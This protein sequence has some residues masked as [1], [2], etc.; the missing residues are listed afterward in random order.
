MTVVDDEPAVIVKDLYKT[1]KLP[2]D[3]HSGIKQYLLTLFKGKK[4][5]KGYEIQHVLNDISF[6]IKKGEFFGI[7]GRN[8][9]GKST[10]LKILAGVYVPDRGLVHINGIL[11]PFIE[12]GVGFNYELTGKENV[13][14]N[15][16][17]LGMSRDEINAI[18]DEIIA[19]AELEDFMDQKLKNYSSGMQ[20]RLAFSIAIRAKSDVIIMDEVLAVGD[21]AF[22]KKCFDVFREL[23]NNG[24]TIILVTHDMG[25]VERFCDRVLIVDKGGTKD[26]VT[27]QE[28]AAVYNRLNV[29]NNL[30]YEEEKKEK[31]QKAP[32]NR[33]G[34]GGIKVESI[35]FYNKKEKTNIFQ[36]GDTID[37]TITLKRNK[38]FETTPFICGLAMYDEND[39]NVFGPNSQHETLKPGATTVRISIPKV[40]IAPGEYKL[41][42]A[43]FNQEMTEPYDFLNKTESFNMITDHT[44][45]GMVYVDTKWESE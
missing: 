9:S 13:Y 41:T 37:I 36:F 18:Y 3:Q 34:K 11:T 12:L 21:A 20:V 38:N 27:P 2:H 6:E 43:I 17:L 39:A 26:I 24:K 42:T 30:A 4:R 7:V 14:L 10:L 29:E 28:A 35:T 44:V 45:H 5:K 23:K 1:F 16:A 19:F 8:G 31:A 15:G 22:Q 25:N 40:R 33:W 32:K